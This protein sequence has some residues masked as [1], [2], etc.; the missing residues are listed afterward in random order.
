MADHEGNRLHICKEMINAMGAD[1]KIQIIA[2]R[3]L[4]FLSAAISSRMTKKI[5]A[6]SGHTI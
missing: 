4:Y 3:H 1:F 5:H 2:C 6:I